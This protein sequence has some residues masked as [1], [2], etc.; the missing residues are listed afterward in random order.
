MNLKKGLIN[1]I[2]GKRDPR[3]EEIEILLDEAKKT[4]EE[5]SLNGKNYLK[6]AIKIKK[7]IC[8]DRGKIYFNKYPEIPDQI[9]EVIEKLN[10]Y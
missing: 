4:G 5:N 10:K 7:N 1:L 8:Q 6:E 3:E 9:K 2:V